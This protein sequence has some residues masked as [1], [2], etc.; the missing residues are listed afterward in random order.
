MRNAAL[1]AI[2]YFA[3]LIVSLV[4]VLIVVRPGYTFSNVLFEVASAQGTV[5]LFTGLS[6]PSMS[7]V[8]E[9]LFIG[10]MWAGRLE[11]LPLLV[12]VRRPL[13]DD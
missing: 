3:L 2:L 9:V 11:I 8:A 4:V 12:L 6:A 10:L 1:F 5:G 7:S 13:V